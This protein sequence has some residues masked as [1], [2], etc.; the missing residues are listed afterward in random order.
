MPRIISNFSVFS[1]QVASKTPGLISALL[2]VNPL[3]EGFDRH[4]LVLASNLTEGEAD[5]Y[6][7]AVGER[8][9]AIAQFYNAFAV[10]AGM[11]KLLVPHK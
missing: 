3:R 11:T 5:A 4:A 8:D 6:V 10:P 1:S 7:S 2:L 9:L